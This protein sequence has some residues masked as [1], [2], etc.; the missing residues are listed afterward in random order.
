MN[1]ALR[2][3]PDY[4]QALTWRARCRHG[5]GAGVKDRAGTAGSVLPPQAVLRNYTL[6]RQLTP[7]EYITQSEGRIA[8]D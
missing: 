6:P 4:L 3:A 8:Q 5:S 1:T 7:C 2:P